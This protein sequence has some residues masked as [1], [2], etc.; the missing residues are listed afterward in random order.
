ML[1]LE[2]Q[3]IKC[4]QIVSAKQFTKNKTKKDGLGSYCLE[5]NGVARREWE[6]NNPD[7]LKAQKQRRN[8]QDRVK[9]SKRESYQS[10][11]EIILAKLKQQRTGKEGYLK[12]MLRGAKSR[13]KKNNLEFDIDLQYLQSVATDYCPVDGLPFDWERR[14]ETNKSL[15]LATPSLDRIDSSKG[16]VKG[17]VKIIGWKWNA[18][19][20]NMNLD[21]LLL[22]VEYVRNATKSKKVDDF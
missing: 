17:N 1:L 4:R 14:L 8:Q 21:D 11:R 22:L 6:K 2:K 9:Q 15:P 16:Y 13:A 7:K 18:K 19:K 12:T 5:C 20:S 3:C 10:N